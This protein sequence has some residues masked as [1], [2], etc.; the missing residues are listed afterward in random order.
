MNSPITPIEIDEFDALDR[1][2]SDCIDNPGMLAFIYTELPVH[3]WANYYEDLKD[4][5]YERFGLK[6]VPNVPPTCL[7]IDFT[8][9]SRIVAANAAQGDVINEY[10]YK[11]LPMTLRGQRFNAGMIYD[12]KELHPLLYQ[13]MR[14]LGDFRP[15]VYSA[16]KP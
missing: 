13:A 12:Q 1:L 10:T 9:T 7:V 4:T 16:I 3:R 8:N 11:V 14:P 15:T 5:I 6:S 2:V